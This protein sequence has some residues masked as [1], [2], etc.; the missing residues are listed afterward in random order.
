MG[1][2]ID[3]SIELIK[4]LM[5]A[6]CR[7]NPGGMVMINRKHLTQF[8]VAL[9]ISAVLSSSAGAAILIE[10]QQTD[11]ISATGSNQPLT[12]VV[13]GGS[14]VSIT[15]FG[16]FDQAQVAGNLKWLIFDS[17]Q[18]T[19]PVFLSSA[20][21]VVGNPGTFADKAAWYDIT[22]INLTLLAGHTYAMGV[23]ADRVGTSSFRWGASPDNLSGPYPTLTANGLS[24]PFMQSLE[25]SGV[26]GGVFST[27]PSVLFIDKTTRRQMSLR[28]FGS[29]AGEVPEPASFIIWSL[30]GAIGFVLGFRRSRKPSS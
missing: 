28:I 29:E 20:Q 15:G 2:I 9:S 11:F 17:N 27:T 4:I 6:P 19:S 16:V 26:V 10:N 13:V 5:L 12:K 14:D 24:L 8:F 18:L 21:A 3:V 22:N 25:N 23:I 7:H 1:E 30:L